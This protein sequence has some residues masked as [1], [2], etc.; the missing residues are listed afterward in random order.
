MT[1]FYGL[2][3]FGFR[4]L[5]FHALNRFYLLTSLAL[6]LM[7]PML[8]YERQEVVI[9]E[10][11]PASEVTYSEEKPIQSTDN[12]T[13]TITPQSIEPQPIKIDWMQILTIIY[14]SGMIMMLFIFLRNM[15]IILKSLTSASHSERFEQNG[16][17]IIMVTERSR[18][19]VTEQS[20]SPQSNASFFNYIFLNPDNLNSHEQTLII[21]HESFHAKKL[22]TIDLL[23]V[24]LLKAIFWFN[25]IIYFYQKSLKQ[26]HEYE[27]DSLMSAA[28]NSQ[29]YAHL[30]LKLGVAPNSLIINQFS[31]KPL[32]DR[33]QFLFKTPTKNLKKLLYF[34]AIPIIGIGIA[35]FA[36]EKVRV[37]YQEKEGEKKELNKGSISTE[38]V[39]VPKVI[40]DTLI[41]KKTIENSIDKFCR[42]I[43]FML[44]FEQIDSLTIIADG[45]VLMKDKDFVIKGKYVYLDQ[46]YEKAKVSIRVQ[47]SANIGGPGSYYLYPNLIKLEEK[48]YPMLNKVKNLPIFV[49]NKNNMTFAYNSKLPKLPTAFSQIAKN[50]E[51]VRTTFEAYKLGENPLV[52]INRTEYPSSILYRLNP[53]AIATQYISSPDD[54]NTILLY[55]EKA[56][57]GC[58][59]IETKK[60]IDLF[61]NDEESSKRVI[62]NVKKQIQASKK[63]VRREIIKDADGK[64]YERI[65]V[66]RLHGEDVHFSVV[67]PIGGKALYIVDG[68]VMSEDEV[69]N[70]NQKFIWGGC[71]KIEGIFED[72]LIVRHGEYVK[73]YDAYF[74]LNSK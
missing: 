73:K 10:P 42:P 7:I 29:E 4:K 27:V 48:P 19:L 52:I 56:K 62:E 3:F 35:A 30:L 72:D 66:M 31:T 36:Q 22:H 11:I 23:L 2:Y 13:L 24:S 61:L 59:E 69:D 64:E 21:A 18:S 60:G 39:D 38:I 65:S 45:Q 40:A 5:T 54:K 70:S 53:D 12:Q 15:I 58:I 17:T 25:P 68:K 28:Y 46:K 44:N 9:V 43:D 16:N 8:N 26:I 34:L 20:P 33:I 57:D 1:V 50:Q 51:T 63:R 41:K 47:T 37:I 55:G 6:S 49:A 71:G 74:K 32:S 14:L 67:V